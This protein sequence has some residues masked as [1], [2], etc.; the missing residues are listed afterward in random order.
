MLTL[1]ASRSHRNPCEGL[2]RRDFFQVGALGLGGLSLAD[3]L[4]LRAQGAVAEKRRAKS[5]IMFSLG[6]GRSH[7]DMY[8]LKPDA[9]SEIRG[10]FTPIRTKVPGLDIC[11]LMPLQAKIADK[12]SIVRGIR[13]A[14]D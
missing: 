1:F 14:R 10:E 13:F 6:G 3:L 8:D 4:R 12:F 2:S 11:E 7:I 9:P 5:V